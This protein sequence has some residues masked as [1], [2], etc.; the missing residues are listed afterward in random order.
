MD[1][2]ARLQELAGAIASGE[3]EA[4]LGERLRFDAEGHA[5]DRDAALAW[6]ATAPRAT[7][8]ATLVSIKRNLTFV[9]WLWPGVGDGVAV[10]SWDQDGRVVHAM[11][12]KRSKQ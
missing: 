1:L 10:L 5:G 4:L 11:V 9:D 6:L 8:T 2:A 3:A 7:V 12:Q